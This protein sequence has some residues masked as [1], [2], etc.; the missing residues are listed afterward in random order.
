[1]F[2]IFH[3]IVV[4]LHHHGTIAECLYKE[5]LLHNS[6]PC[7]IAEELTPDFCM[8]MLSAKAG[9]SEKQAE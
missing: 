2:E 1:M 3:C 4:S 7:I 8:K 9:L 5:L 6:L